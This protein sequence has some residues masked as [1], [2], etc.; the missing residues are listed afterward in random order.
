MDRYAQKAAAAALAAHRQGKFWVFHEKLFESYKSLN[1][2]RI[3]QIAGEVGLDM[4]KFNKDR[5]SAAIQEIIN[6]DIRDAR[7]LGV[8][9]TP[10]I[11][12]NGRRL[13]QR[14][15]AGFKA[16]IDPLLKRK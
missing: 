11:F 12:I 15:L 14:S 1:D 8:G 13:N 7:T 2:A 3:Q 4:E 6:R 5:E 16:M 9:G 10:V